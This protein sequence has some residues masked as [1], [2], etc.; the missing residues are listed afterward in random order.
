MNEDENE[1]TEGPG[2]TGYRIEGRIDCHLTSSWPP[3]ACHASYYVRCVSAVKV[4]RVSH[5][6]SQS[7]IH[8]II[9]YITVF[10]HI[11]GNNDGRWDKL[12]VRA[13]SPPAHN[14]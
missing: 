10:L 2:R 8:F 1:G 13:I 3:E 12:S 6:V 7:P 14:D 5:N 4:V 9:L 11:W